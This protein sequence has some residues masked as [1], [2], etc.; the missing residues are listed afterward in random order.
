MLLHS[1]EIQKS[2]PSGTLFFR[3]NR[4]ALVIIF[5]VGQPGLEPGTPSPPDSYANHLRYYPTKKT[6]L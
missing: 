6:T 2:V 3:G 1:G 5:L 4:F